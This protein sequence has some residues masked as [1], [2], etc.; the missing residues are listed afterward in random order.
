MFRYHLF[1]IFFV[2]FTGDSVTDFYGKNIGQVI[3]EKNIAKVALVFTE[4]Y[5]G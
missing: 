4:T 2:L 3:S 1:T 5:L